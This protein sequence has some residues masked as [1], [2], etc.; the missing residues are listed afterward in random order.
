[1]LQGAALGTDFDAVDRKCV[2]IT[3]LHLDLTDYAS[4]DRMKSLE[5]MSYAEIARHRSAE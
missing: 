1:M 3:P 4:F 5:K 2:S